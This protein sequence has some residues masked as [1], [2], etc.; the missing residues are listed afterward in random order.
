MTAPGEAKRPPR[1]RARARRA[2]A[3]I[4]LATIALTRSPSRAA[5]P[6]SLRRFALVVGSNDGGPA[7]VRLRY[8]QSDAQ[9]FAQ[10]L[11]GWGGVARADRLVVLEPTLDR[12]R[13]AIGDLHGRVRA[14]SGARRVEVLFY[15]SG[16]SD[17]EGLLPTGARLPYQELRRAIDAM[18]ADVRIV[19]LDSCSSGAL[20]RR[21]GGTRRPP[22]LV[23]ESGRVTGHAFLTSSAAEEAAQ[24]SDRIGGSF[25]THYLVS[26][27]RGAADASRD[28]R[29]T[30]SEAYQFA[31]NETLARTERT[32]GGPQHP[33]Y[34]I[35][36][37]G[38][39]DL[40]MTD[41]RQ[42]SAGLVVAREVDG[43]LFVRDQRG[44][45]V[46]EVTKAPTHAIEL[47]LEP[48]EYRVTLDRGGR[49][50]AL[51]LRIAAGGRARIGGDRFTEQAPEAVALRGGTEAALAR[52][53]GDYKRR[54]FNLSLLPT[55]SL[56]GDD[57]PRTIEQFSLNVVGQAARL[58]GAEVG[59][60]L[61]WILEDARWFQ[62][63]VGANLVGGS[64]QG[65]QLAGGANVVKGRVEGAQL[66][67][68]AS[69]A[70]RGVRGFQV[71]DGLAWTEALVGVQLAAVTRSTDA[72][73]GQV[74]IV[75]VGGSIEGL[76]LGLVNVATGKVRGAQIGLLNV[77]DDVEGAPIGLVSW[78]R[79]GMLRGQVWGSDTAL[80]NVGLQLGSRHVYSLVSAGVTPSDG[81]ARWL[82]GF[83]LG[84]HLPITE[85]LWSA[86]DVSALAVGR[87]DDT[88]GQPALLRVR[89]SLGWQA[90]DRFGVFGGPALNVYSSEKDDGKDL[91]LGGPSY[92][93]TRG[94]RRVR[95]WPGFFLGVRI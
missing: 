89:L 46:V 69:W 74:G 7:R 35:Q 68:G 81:K 44:H 32:S 4:A 5:E 50:Y 56:A 45:L 24:E 73:G 2:L 79:K 20:T 47:G 75:N 64:F 53:A 83:G 52:A 66:A 31:F 91:V 58:E 49:V 38:T 17:E 14:A 13:E 25:F 62:L 92:T 6:V 19:V 94:G 72:H 33:A 76:Q 16:H 90:S 93:D 95:V 11:E 77:A 22:F 43:R 8:A 82:A 70:S 42:T 26:G 65:V 54:A 28:G 18:P 40:V 34:D 29:V 61:N 88:E 86:L 27:L 59:L 48:G 60:G 57:S 30:L 21:K 41:L 15:Y 71:A 3:A 9:A 55:V 10:V 37:A 80:S 84:G 1:S 23:D 63:A 67:V 12:L 51:E 39:G 87:G 85:T 36:L 78:V